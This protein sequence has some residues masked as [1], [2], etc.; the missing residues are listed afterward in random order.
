MKL[1]KKII[2]VM[3]VVCSLFLVTVI[4]LTYFMLFQAKEIANSTYNQRIWAKEEKV[5]RGDRKCSEFW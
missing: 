5:L 2:T 4:Y 1:N 3:S